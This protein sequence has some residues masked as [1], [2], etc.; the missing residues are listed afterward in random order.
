MGALALACPAWGRFVYKYTPFLEDGK[1][2][3]YQ[4]QYKDT[5]TSL[6]T[7]VCGFVLEERPSA[8]EGVTVMACNVVN[9]RYENVFGRPIAML[10]EDV[11]AH[12]V[13]VMPMIKEV[14]D[15]YGPVDMYVNPQVRFVAAGCSF[16]YH[17]EGMPAVVPGYPGYYG[18]YNPDAFPCVIYDFNMWARYT[19]PDGINLAMNDWGMTGTS[20]L[21]LKYVWANPDPWCVMAPYFTEGIGTQELC[22]TRVFLCPYYGYVEW[23]ECNLIDPALMAVREKEGR[24]LYCLE[25]P[26]SRPWENLSGM[27]VPA[28]Q[29]AEEKI[30]DLSGREIEAPEPGRPYIRNGQKYIG[31]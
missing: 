8:E 31:R 17:A 12:R 29:R 10:Y 22:A 15:D 6:K 9:E 30:Y 2:W 28:A 26:V 14:F 4:G 18:P 16:G 23:N 7:F 24:M 3:W 25:N 21:L 11:E 1:E 5:P 19:T 27:V 20:T 13:S